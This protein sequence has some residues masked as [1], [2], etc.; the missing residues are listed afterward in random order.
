MSIYAVT[1][2]KAFEGGSDLWVSPEPEVSELTKELNWYTNF[3]TSRMIYHRPQTVSPVLADILAKNEIEFLGSPP[4][5]PDRF[6]LCTEHVVPNKLLLVL[7]YKGGLKS[8]LK[9]AH[10]VWQELGQPT[11]RIFLPKGVD[12]DQFSKAWPEKGA[13]QEVSIVGL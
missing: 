11:V 8:W 13:G 9:Q 2:A 12:V 4:E 3:L 5:T 6:L 10:R 1:K 7:P